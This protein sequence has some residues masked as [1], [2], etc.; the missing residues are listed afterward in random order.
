MP[1]ELEDHI[2]RVYELYSSENREFHILFTVVIGSGTVFLAVLLG[3]YYLRYTGLESQAQDL[4]KA[5]DELSG[6]NA[7]PKAKDITDTV[8]ELNDIRERI[9]S[10]ERWLILK[11]ST[12]V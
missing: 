1:G 11:R 3:Q 7:L 4:N 8:T 10:S 12:L 5:F 9:P 6:L 2:S